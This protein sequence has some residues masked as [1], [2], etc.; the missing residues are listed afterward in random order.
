MLSN[1]VPMPAQGIVAKL[2]RPNEAQSIS[3]FETFLKSTGI[4]I[5]R[6]S[7]LIDAH[8]LASKWLKVNDR[9]EYDRRE[10]SSFPQS[11]YIGL[12]YALE[13]SDWD[14]ARTEAKKLR[15][16]GATAETFQQSLMKPFTKSLA[17]DQRLYKSLDKHDKAIFD[18]ALK[19]RAEV[20]DRY[21]K[22][23]NSRAQ[24]KHVTVQTLHK[25]MRDAEIA[26][27]KKKRTKKVSQSR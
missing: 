13:D 8:E 5:H 10:A 9:A 15:E 27:A 4:Q 14:A 16:G 20:L 2:T 7:P 18:A 1:I 3:P 17:D 23:V 26:E 19:R 22:H 12:R 11:K 25:K 24:V 6:V 21:R